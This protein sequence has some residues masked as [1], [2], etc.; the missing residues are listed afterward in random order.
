VTGQKLEDKIPRH[1]RR[2]RLAD[3]DR[4]PKLHRSER[5]TEDQIHRF[6]AAT[7][8][9]SAKM[10]RNGDNLFSDTPPPPPPDQRRAEPKPYYVHAET[11]APGFP[12]PP[13]AGA[14]AGGEGNPRAWP[15][16]TE[17][18][19]ATPFSPSLSREQGP[20]PRRKQLMKSLIEAFDCAHGPTYVWICS[21]VGLTTRLFS[22]VKKYVRPL[23][24]NLSASSFHESR[25]PFA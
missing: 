5:P 16:R 2:R 13:A 7:P 25:S 23:P 22:T 10:G 1:G 9:S 6:L 20:S 4:E 14:A 12:H 15:R 3:H 17:G 21:I 18:T 11:K 8:Q 24:P 19:S